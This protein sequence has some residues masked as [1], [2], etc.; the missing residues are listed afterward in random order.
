MIG[1]KIALLIAAF[2]G[3]IAL[4][5]EILWYRVFSLASS[6]TAQA[7]AFVLGAYL[8][9][10]AAGS[11][12]ARVLAN[13]SVVRYGTGLV[14]SLSAFIL[15]ANVTSYLV[16][17]SVATACRTGHCFL[18]LAAVGLAAALLG[19][20][21]PLVCHLAVPADRLA[22][23]RTSHIYAANILGS[24]AGA[25]VTGYLLLEYL[26]AK[27][28]AVVLLAAGMLLATL[29]LTGSPVR[30]PLRAAWLVLLVGVGALIGWISAPPLDSLYERLIYRENYRPGVRFAHTLENRVGVIN[31]TPTA[32]VFGGGVY[33]GYARVDLMEDP[34]TLTRIVAVPAFHSAPRHV[35]MIGLSMGAWA[36]VVANFP[37]VE[38]VTIVEINPGYLDLIPAYPDVAS[39]LTDRKVRVVV[40]DGRRW[41][42][43]H[44]DKRFDLIV[45]NVT[46]HWREHA[47]NLLSWEF[48]H[49]VRA[50]LEPG[51]AYFYN[52]TSAPEA[53]RTGL[54]VFPYG[55][56]VLGFMA[57]SERPLMFR[58]DTFAAIVA[59][60]RVNGRPLLDPTVPAQARRIAELTALLS[61]PGSPDSPPFFEDGAA[62]LHRIGEGAIITDDNMAVEWYG[63]AAEAE[64]P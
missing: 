49:L 4:S 61:A 26:P 1:T 56:R 3:F 46:F 25:L 38:S 36:Q 42:V 33:D 13:R 47:T 48:L 12:V 16:L 7:F 58:P 64:K 39:L 21:F 14:V 63:L 18:P 45:A 10:L 8:Y 11:F 29:P 30:S 22:G 31:I 50:H 44:P 37:S 43:R 9:G 24:T 5:Y 55:L 52:A 23:W 57:V 15:G 41:L 59:A 53:F 27:R 34:N 6:G 32:R 54:A 19:S 20:V 2:S 40:D 60:V 51:G 28:L 62:L 35:L 17:P